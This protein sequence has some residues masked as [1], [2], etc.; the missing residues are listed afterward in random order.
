[1]PTQT[2]QEPIVST[3]IESSPGSALNDRYLV[4]SPS[5]IAGYLRGVARDR[6]MCSVRAAGKPESFLSQLIA[7]D[8]RGQLVFDAPRAPVILRSLSSVGRASV[9]FTLADV[10]IVFEVDLLRSGDYQ[11]DQVVFLRMPSSIHR[12][13][14]RDNYRVSVPGRRPVRLSLDSNEPLLKDLKLADLSC[15]GASVNLRGTLEHFPIGRQFEA[16][17]LVIE[18]DQEPFRLVLRVRHAVAVR[19]SGSIGDLRIGVQFVRTPAGF[20]PAVSRLVNEIARD[21]MRIKQ[22]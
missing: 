20:E 15:G 21:L 2:L 19:L 22:A 5:E 13:Q 10:R 1:M 3:S 8:D 11:G 6:V 18:E 14:R 16:A 12:F 9:E 4:H 7:I 17:E